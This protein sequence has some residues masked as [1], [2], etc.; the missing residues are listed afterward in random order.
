MRELKT[1]AVNQPM[2]VQR[3]L[4]CFRAAFRLGVLGQ[5]RFQYWH[6]IIW[7]LIRRPRLIPVAISLSIYGYH[8]H[9]IFELYIL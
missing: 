7:T 6:L 3:F 2:N 1:P 4:S 5:E 8:Y 9:K